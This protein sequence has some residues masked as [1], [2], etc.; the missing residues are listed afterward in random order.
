VKGKA[1]YAKARR[2][3]IELKR[4]NQAQAETISHMI[5]DY[6]G[7][8]AGVESR[9][10]GTKIMEESLASRYSWTFFR[11]LVFAFTGK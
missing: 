3:Y 8:L 11:R 2:S 1:A 7:K 5:D 4:R 6:R 9:E 10:V